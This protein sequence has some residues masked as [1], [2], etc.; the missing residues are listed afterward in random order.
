LKRD[1][2]SDP[3][4]GCIRRSTHRALV[5]VTE[6]C[7]RDHYHRQYLAITRGGTHIGA[8]SLPLHQVVKQRTGRGKLACRPLK[9][10]YGNTSPVNPYCPHVLCGRLPAIW[11]VFISALAFVAGFCNNSRMIVSYARVSTFTNAPVI[12]SSSGSSTDLGAV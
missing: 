1:H 9:P 5:V 10:P 12:S 3:D 2:E 11:A 6:W 7:Y 8:M 4:K